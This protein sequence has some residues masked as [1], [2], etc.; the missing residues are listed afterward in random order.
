M[1][2]N[3]AGKLLDNTNFRRN[4]LEPSALATGV[5]PFTPH[6]LRDTAASLAVSA[7]A[8]VKVIQRML[9][10][11]SAAMTL[12]VYSG[13]FVDDLD[14]VALRLNEGAQRAQ[15]SVRMAASQAQV[16]PFQ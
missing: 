2:V 11:A 8:N 5:S 9:G 3:G 12:D 6:N 16:L 4:V 13:L 7:G 1:F 14:D 10:H 15:S